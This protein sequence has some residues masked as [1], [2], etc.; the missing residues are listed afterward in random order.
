MERQEPAY[1]GTLKSTVADPF[2]ELIKDAI[3]RGVISDKAKSLEKEVKNFGL[4]FISYSL[5]HI[6]REAQGKG[7]ADTLAD[8]RNLRAAIEDVTQRLGGMSDCFGIERRGAEVHLSMD[9]S[10]DRAA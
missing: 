7:N 10:D 1:K 5:E 2:K 9:P 3:D 4:L 6:E 8:V